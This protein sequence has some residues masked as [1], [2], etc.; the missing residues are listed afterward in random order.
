MKAQFFVTQAAA[1]GRKVL[2]AQSAQMVFGRF[3]NKH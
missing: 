3:A 2:T 1:A